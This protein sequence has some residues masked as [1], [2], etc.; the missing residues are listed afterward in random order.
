MTFHY[1]SPEAHYE[2][3]VQVLT[4]PVNPWH[5]LNVIDVTKRIAQ[6]LPYATR[7]DIERVIAEELFHNRVPEA[8]APAWAE[9]GVVLQGLP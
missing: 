7:K 6:T 4:N 2:A 1:G 3:V 9:L 8:L 5:T